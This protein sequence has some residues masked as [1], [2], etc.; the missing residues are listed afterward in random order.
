[1]AVLICK[2]IKHEGPG[3][4]ENYLTTHNIPYKIIDLS[5]GEKIPGHESFDVL[6]LMGGPMSVTD[7]DAYAYLQKESELVKDF[8]EKKKK[9]LGI[10]LGAQIMAKAL[11]ARV[12][13]GAEDEIGWYDVELT[14][15]G[16][17]DPAIKALSFDSKKE[18][19][20]RKIK[21]FHWHGETF[22]MPA[23]A[24]RL[25][26]SERYPNQA[27]RYKE[28]AYAFQ[29]HIEVNKKMIYDWFEETPLYSDK[30]RKETEQFYDA[31]QNRAMQFYEYFFK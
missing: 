28:N 21:V 22:T 16:L 11:G 7:E 14:D 29:F 19:L 3:T 1:M 30:L 26:G 8:V 20:S 23:S 9:I 24:I 15:E 6:I 2:N 5:R 25:A 27:F 18:N 13:K 31:Y 12:Y 17:K 4:I 10:C